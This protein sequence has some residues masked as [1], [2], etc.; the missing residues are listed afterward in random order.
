M[1]RYAAEPR[2]SGWGNALWNV[3]WWFLYF[4]LAVWV[5]LHFPGVDAMLPGLLISLQEKRWQQTAW[6]ALSCILLQEGTG[7][8]AFGGTLLWYGGMFLLFMGGR[9]FFVTNSLFFVVLLSG[10]LGVLNILVLLALTSLQKLAFSIEPA[11]EQSLAQAMLIPPLWG[12]AVLTR[13]K[14]FRHVESRV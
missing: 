4:V 1:N 5:Q 6:V 9:W 10:A 12:L 2:A 8:L 7:T 3:L 14:V 13:K 11:L